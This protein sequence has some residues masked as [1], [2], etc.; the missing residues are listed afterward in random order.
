MHHD[1]N[2]A[3]GFITKILG[4]ISVAMICSAVFY[5]VGDSRAV[6][7]DIEPMPTE[8]AKIIHEFP[9]KATFT[10]PIAE[11]GKVVASVPPI[12]ELQATLV[13]SESA[14]QESDAQ[15][16][17]TENVEPVEESI[18]ERENVLYCFVE[19]GIRTDVPIEYQDYI[20]NLLKENGHEDKYELILAMIYHESGYNASLVS[21][22]NDYGLMQINKCNHK[23]LR[24]T[25]GITDFLDPY[26]SIDAG[27]YIISGYFDKYDSAEQALVCYNMGEGGALKKG[28]TSSTYSRGVFSDIELLVELES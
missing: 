9:S 14:P 15:P 22:T 10:T 5:F 6:H 24:E 12:T 28:I 17:C 27:V 20:W 18:P 13:T 19:D 3:G 8:S 1:Y 21:K 11:V 16:E 23:W 26:Q 2:R 7:Y 4:I 25:L